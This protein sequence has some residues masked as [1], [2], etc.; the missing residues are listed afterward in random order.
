[1]KR[2]DPAIYSP[3]IFCTGVHTMKKQLII[4]AIACAVSGTAF[5]ATE[6]S[7]TINL[8]VDAPIST[9]EFTAP[10][11][12]L[13]GTTNW[14]L[15][16]DRLGWPAHNFRRDLGTFTLSGNGFT[17]ET[18]CRLHISSD[19]SALGSPWELKAPGIS[20]GIQYGITD[21]PGTQ[22]RYGYYYVGGSTWSLVADTEFSA[23]VRSDK[24]CEDSIN[25]TISTQ[26]VS[27]LQRP[28]TGTYTDT[29][30][31]TVSAS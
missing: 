9:L 27:T 2:P 30:R 21:Y 22:A 24:T 17:N 13:G 16:V 18:A 6:G 28:A 29:I 25:L 20:T 1:M 23:P 31:F 5:A 14:N 10:A 12:I 7:H 8:T 3:L 4:A 19:N 15:D 11:T 26:P